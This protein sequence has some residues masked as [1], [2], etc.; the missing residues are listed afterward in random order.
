MTQTNLQ[1]TPHDRLSEPADPAGERRAVMA[2]SGISLRLWRL[3]A[4]F[5]L[6]CLLFPV[7]FL[8]QTPLALARL[9]P[10]V[11]GLVLFVGT[12][13][14][15][16]WPHPANRPADIRSNGGTNAWL[17]AG[18]ALLALIL[19]LANG[20]AFLWLFVGVSAVA[21][22]ALSPRTAFVVVMT[23]TLITLGLSVG[24]SGGLGQ[25][26]WLHV[27]PLVLLVRGLGLDL[28]GL[29]R[30]SA[31]LRELHLARGELARQ[32]VVQ[33]RLRL[34]RDLHDL[35]G[36]TLSLITL[37]SE[38]AGRLVDK[39][40]EQATQEI[41]EIEQEA[42]R[43]LREVRQAVMGYR[44][45]TLHIELEGARQ[46]LAAAGIDCL[47]EGGASNLARTV[48]G[49]LAWTVREGVTNVIRHS[50][51]RHCTIR[52]RSAADR[53][54]VELINDGNHTEESSLAANLPGSGLTGLAE[55]VAGLN[56]QLEAGVLP[57]EGGRGYRLWVSL[58]LNGSRGLTA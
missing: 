15:F 54:T 44:Q 20:A 48:D 22:V 29:T 36:H 3:Y 18:L 49:V 12:Y 57:W 14:W 42:R 34:A 50:R 23:L 56:G 11:V 26:D 21:G 40:P 9:V 43:A 5:W 52:V 6:V 33:E 19:T 53:A 7:L 13:T 47:I 37:K 17:F 35:L 55:R 1:Q 39:H 58:P 2:S 8:A 25:T 28:A 51:A 30:L 27:I 46:I 31:A 4:Q 16:M 45:P 38:L 41:R 32:A 24:L 10:V